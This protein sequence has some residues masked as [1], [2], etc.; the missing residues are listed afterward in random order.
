MTV[1]ECTGRFA[2]LSVVAAVP[3]IVPGERRV[4]APAMVRPRRS[5]SANVVMPSPPYRVPMTLKSA[6]LVAMLSS[7]PSQ[8]AQPEGA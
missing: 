3:A 6:E 2:T 4:L 7:E 8:S 5:G 1:C